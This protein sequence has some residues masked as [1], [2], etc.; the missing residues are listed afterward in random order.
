[1]GA[2]ASGAVLA[3]W[4]AACPFGGLWS[5]SSACPFV[6]FDGDA[7]AGGG[8][9]GDVVDLVATLAIACPMRGPG[10]GVLVFGAAEG[11]LP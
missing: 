7:V 4:C 3:I 9:D 5:A 10:I 11:D 1:M 2:V 6:G 8:G